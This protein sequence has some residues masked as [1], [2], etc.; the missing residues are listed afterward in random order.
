MGKE[1]AKIKV[2]SIGL[3]VINEIL[4]VANKTPN[5]DLK[6]SEY[7]LNIKYSIEVDNEYFKNVEKEALAK[8]ESAKKVE[9]VI[10]TTKG[11]E[12]KEK[13]KI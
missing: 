12:K 11:G 6:Y 9:E 10:D 4:E 1:I 13:D 8:K 3:Q 2:N 7:L 5:A